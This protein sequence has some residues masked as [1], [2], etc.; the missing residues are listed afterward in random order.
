VGGRVLSERSS[1]AIHNIETIA[2]LEQEFLSQR[3]SVERV[4]DA[5][6][7]F[8]GTV[9]FVAIQLGG[10][11]GWVLV[12]LG[13]IPGVKPFDPFPFILLAL[14]VTAEGVLLTTFVLMKQNRM[15]KR[16]EQR[17]QLN[18]QINLLAE[19]EITTILEMLRAVCDHLGLKEAHQPE[20]RELSRHTGV[21]ALARKLRDR[22]PE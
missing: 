20:V 11:M 19:K 18:L 15:S 22:M 3:T 2:R 7:T 5:I 4:A 13:F 6:A 14:V 10:V 21:E 1:S 12:N 17:D 8:V 16:A 9:P